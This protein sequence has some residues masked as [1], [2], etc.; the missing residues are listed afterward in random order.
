MI[1]KEITIVQY[2]N[3]LEKE[4]DDFVSSAK[5][6]YFFFKRSFMEYH[7]ERF[8]DHSLMFY[9]GSRLIAILPAHLS[10]NQLC[11]H[12]GL[13]FAGF[14]LSNEAK[15]VKMIKLVKALKVYLKDR[16]INTFVYKAIPSVYHL[17]P[18]D[19]DLVALFKEGA[20]LDCRDFTSVIKLD[21][22]IKLSKGKRGCVKKAIKSGLLVRESS[23]LEKFFKMMEELLKE[24]YD[25]KPVHSYEEIF[26]LQSNF[27]EN[28]KLYAVYKDEELVAGTLVFIDKNIAKTQYIS[29]TEI[30]RDAGAVDLL[31]NY[32]IQEVFKDKE[33]FD[34]GTST[35]GNE[36]G[37][38]ENLLAQKELFGAR[39]VAKDVYLLEL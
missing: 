19:E 39:A 18:C 7:S 25:I 21:D 12:M 38:N 16:G 13:T 32:L 33:F 15:L 17:R 27:P 23:D 22:Q 11:S 31:I 30:G 5:N 8:D 29:S 20:I 4:W 10:L 36:L 6:S 3:S 28:I 35:E 26:M 14:I 37:F 24:K 1:E 34:F 9:Y 2:H